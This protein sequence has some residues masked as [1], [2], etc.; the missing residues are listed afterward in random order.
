MKN[1]HWTMGSVLLAFFVL[2]GG[3]FARDKTHEAAVSMLG[4]F[5]ADPAAMTGFASQHAAGLPSATSLLAFPAR[6]QKG[7]GGVVL[8]IIQKS[9]AGAVKYADT[10]KTSGTKGSFHSFSPA[11]QREI[12]EI[13][14]ELEKDPEF[15]EKAGILR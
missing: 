1:R 6:I 8:M 11:V 7:L 4:N 14:Q 12:Q 9:G 5:F 13:T 2:A 3:A 10:L 15:M